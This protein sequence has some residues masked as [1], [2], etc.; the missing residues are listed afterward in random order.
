MIKQYAIL[1]LLAGVVFVAGGSSCPQLWD[2][3][4]TH[5]HVTDAQEEGTFSTHGD[6]PYF[7][8]VGFRSTWTTPGST[9]VFW[10]GALDDDWAD[11]IDDGGDRDIPA[12]MGKLEFGRVGTLYTFDEIRDG[13]HPQLLGAVV[14]AMESDNTPFSSVRSTV[15]DDLIPALQNQ[16]IHL[17]E[18]GNVSVDHVDQALADARDAI[19]SAMRL[20]T[21]EKIGAVI[22]AGG[23]PDDKIGDPHVFAFPVVDPAVID[24]VH[25]FRADPD[26]VTLMKLEDSSLTESFAGDGATYAVTVTGTLRSDSSARSSGL[27]VA[28]ELSPERLRQA[29]QPLP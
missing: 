27:D 15:N 16:L 19:Q 3:Q 21:L 23:D 8:V 9:R 2:F 7:I 24:L 1:P 20:T 29:L 10:N 12:S 17:V 11:G 26:G 13:A 5:L 4:I 28:F 22:L 14:I 6:E 25:T 18:E